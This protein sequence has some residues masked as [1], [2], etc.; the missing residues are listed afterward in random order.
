KGETS[1]HVQRVR[2]LY[3]DCDGDTI[4]VK[5]DQTGVAC[6]EGTYSCFSR[7]LDSGECAQPS[8]SLPTSILYELFRV[9]S[10]RKANPKEGSYTTY[11]F[12]KGQDKILKKVGEEAAE[13]IIAS[14]NN[15]KDEILYEMADLW[16]HCL[17]L[18][19][20]HNITPTELLS[21]LAGRRK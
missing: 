13:T 2:E 8:K 9:I 4:L 16:Y 15:S 19:A 12:D 5:A 14:K 6:H 21:E 17:V 1:G 11:L 3:Y 20:Y 18:L 10:D 7:R